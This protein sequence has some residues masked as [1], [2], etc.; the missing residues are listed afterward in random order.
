MALDFLSV[1]FIVKKPLEQRVLFHIFPKARMVP[2]TI[3]PYHVLS[4]ELEKPK[5]IR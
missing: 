3:K 4:D 2:G 1:S 5:K